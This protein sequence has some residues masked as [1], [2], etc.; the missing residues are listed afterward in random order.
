MDE[1]SANEYFTEKNN[2]EK[3]LEHEVPC[4]QVYPIKFLLVEYNL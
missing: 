4:A 3:L 2:I 1:A